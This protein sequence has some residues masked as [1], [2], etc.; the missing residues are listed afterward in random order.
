M[1]DWSGEERRGENLAL[2]VMREMREWLDSHEKEEFAKHEAL[3][4]E[5][6]TWQSN[7]QTRHEDA[8]KRI[9]TMGQSTLAVVSQ[10]NQSIKEQGATIKE[11]HE[12]F[13]AAFP[14]GDPVR[15]RMVHEKQEQDEKDQRETLMK[16]KQH[17]I[18]W[19][20]VTVIGW[21]SVALWLAF[22]QG[23]HK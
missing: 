20:A 18:N 16:L 23:P 14:S 7:A 13:K 9:D 22:L 19:V 21:G 1:S 10:Q 15:H 5:I 17:I 4:D 8:M 2:G 6:H 11:I 12:M 3:R